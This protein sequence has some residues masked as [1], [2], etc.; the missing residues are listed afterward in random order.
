M[1]SP[2]AGRSA[3]VTGAT[4]GIGAAV[5]RALAASGARVLLVART[6][7]LLERAVAELPHGAVAIRADLMAAGAAARVAQSVR[8][9]LGGDGAAGGAGIGAGRGG[10]P[11]II[12]HAAGTFP[13]APFSD[14]DDA[15]IEEALALNA[16]VP[17][18]LTRE[19]LPAMRARG[20]GHVVM[21]GSIADRV[22]FPSNAAYS[23]SKHALRAVHETL[24]VETRG[25]GLRAT[26]VSPAATDTPIW[27]QHLAAD[28]PHLPA[29]ADML[30]AE[31]VADAV[32]WA[33]TRPAHVDIEELRL[34]R[35]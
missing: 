29:R 27:D 9:A 10:A 3:L 8:A 19:F 31:D 1:S 14:A 33:V 15:T 4:R 24:R 35:S 12:V 5:A 2:L 7:D 16:A 20:T 23:A 6:P 13:M 30:R 28:A 18:R 32:L 25:S 11:D 34:A 21:I 26:L 22:I 17:L